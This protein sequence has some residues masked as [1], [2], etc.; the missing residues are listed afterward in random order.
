[1]WI[2]DF[3]G[4][5]G[6]QALLL[7]LPDQRLVDMGRDHV[8]RRQVVEMRVHR[9]RL[10]GEA[11]GQLFG[12]AGAAAVRRAA[13]ATALAPVLRRFIVVSRLQFVDAHGI[14]PPVAAPRYHRLPRCPA[15][16]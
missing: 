1:V 11:D 2:R 13:S 4:E 8:V 9:R 16:T 3:S 14:R 5:A 10:G 15:R 6:D 7:V 12:R